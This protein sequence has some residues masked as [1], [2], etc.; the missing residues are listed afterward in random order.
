[1]VQAWNCG[2]ALQILW[3]PSSAIKTTP[4]QTEQIE[5]ILHEFVQSRHPTAATMTRSRQ[6][7]EPPKRT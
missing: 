3:A 5:A 7:S 2:N 1:M 6:E 4:Y